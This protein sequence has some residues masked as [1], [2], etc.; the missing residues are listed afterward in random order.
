VPYAHATTYFKIAIQQALR[1]PHALPALI[2]RTRKIYSIVTQGEKR[3]QR[4]QNKLGIPIPRFCIF[5]VT[6]RCNLDCLGCYAKGYAHR[7]DLSLSEIKRVL[8]EGIELGISLYVI[9]GGEP[10]LLPNLIPTLSRITNGFFFLFTNATLLDH[11]HI[12]QLKQAPHILPILSIEG[13]ACCTDNRRGSDVGHKVEEAMQALLGAHIPF[14]FSTMITHENVRDVTSRAWFDTMWRSGARFGFFI[15]YI[16]FPRNLNPSYVLTADDRVYKQKELEQRNKEAHPIVFNLPTDEYK[17]GACMSAGRGFI[18]IN[19]DGFVEPCPFSHVAT[20]N[21][22][23]TSLDKI[24]ASPF[25]REIRAAFDHQPDPH[26]GCLLFTHA[27]Q[28][29]TIARRYGAH[30][31]DS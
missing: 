23:D 17:G 13:E 30:P 8:D 16:P 29:A 28:V 4:N 27:S 3:H 31:T 5:S 22:K 1:A 15:D 19:A 12:E 21:I 25:F 24:L 6:W 18:H 14:G 26:A 11:T 9:A 7:E 20:D 2:K 10:L